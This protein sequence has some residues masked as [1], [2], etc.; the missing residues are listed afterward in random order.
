VGNPDDGDRRAQYAIV[1]TE[2]DTW[3]A[4]LRRVAYDVDATVRALEAQGFVEACGAMGHMWLQELR[5][6][7]S[8]ISPY[9]RWRRAEHPERSG[10]LDLV[11]LF[12]DDKRRAYTQPYKLVAQSSR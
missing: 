7:E 1:E 3:R 2:G 5:T 9:L 12:T 11:P 10:T 6:A 4:E 8:Y